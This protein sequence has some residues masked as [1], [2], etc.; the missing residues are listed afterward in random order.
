VADP[1][2]EVAEYAIILRPDV[3]GVG[4]GRRMM[5]KVVR[6]CRERGTKLIEGHVLPDNERMLN[7]VRSLGFETRL[8]VPNGEVVVRLPLT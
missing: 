8:D 5:E 3:Q 2:N 1:D 6:Y 4:L 7:L